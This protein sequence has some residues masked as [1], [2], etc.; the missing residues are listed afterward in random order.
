MAIGIEVDA[1]FAHGSQDGT[2]EPGSGKIEWFRDHE[3]GPEMVVVPAGSFVLGSPDTEL[4]Y[5]SEV[6]RDINHHRATVRSWTPRSHARP[7]CG[8]RR[9]HQLPDGRRRPV[10]DWNRMDH[11]S[12]GVL[13]QHPT[14]RQP[15]GRLRQLARRKRLRFVALAK[16]RQ[17]LRAPVRGRARIR[18]LAPARRHHS[19]AAS[20]SDRSRRTSTE[21]TLFSIKKIRPEYFVG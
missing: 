12:E 15:P 3:H 20:R 19:G 1:P 8:L 5:P 18:S 4:R 13:E 16:D 11:R 7:V 2:F 21:D 17:D 6:P 9:R 10:L 14:R